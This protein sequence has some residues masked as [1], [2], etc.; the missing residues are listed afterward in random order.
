MTLNMSL[1]TQLNVRID[2][3]LSQCRRRRYI[4]NIRKKK[5]FE[6]TLGADRSHVRTYVKPISSI[7]W[8]MTPS[9]PLRAY[10]RFGAIHGLHLQSLGIAKKEPDIK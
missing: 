7:F 6:C 8:E 4:I 3:A 1:T 2:A 9:S 10:R 5:G